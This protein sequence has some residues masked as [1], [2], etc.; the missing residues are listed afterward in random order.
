MK[1][2]KEYGFLRDEILAQYGGIRQYENLMYT[3]VA[4]MLAFSIGSDY[5]VLCMI[6]Y[7]VIITVYFIV[8]A[9]KGGIVRIATYMIVFLEGDEFNWETRQLEY[10]WKNFK[11]EVKFPWRTHS[12]YYLL[13]FACTIAS[14]LKLWNGTGETLLQKIIISAVIVIFSLM[15]MILFYRKR[16]DYGIM[17]KEMIDHWKEVKNKIDNQQDEPKE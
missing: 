6:P 7:I 9:T 12:Q 5:Y 8:M 13:S 3:A 1:G 4:A 17:K 15:I 10:K 14:L 11:D 2:E 16:F